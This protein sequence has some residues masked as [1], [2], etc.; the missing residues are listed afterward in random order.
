MKRYVIQIGDLYV[1]WMGW[2]AM[3]I[4]KP[5]LDSFDVAEIYL[6]SYFDLIIDEERNLSRKELILAKYP[7]A[8]FVE[9]FI[10]L[11]TEVY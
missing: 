3:V 10:S 11:K 1:K 9:V 7:E 4:P 2:V 8:R 5:L 6:E